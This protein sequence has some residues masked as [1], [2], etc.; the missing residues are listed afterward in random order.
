MLLIDSS[1]LLFWSVTLL[2]TLTPGLA[3][4][5]VL[6]T[7]LYEGR[8]ASALAALGIAAGNSVYL[9]VCVLGLAALL[10]RAGTLL[11]ALRL[12]G[13]AYLV[14]LGIRLL[15][16]RGETRSLSAEKAAHGSRAFGRGF[17]TQIG[18]PKAV[19]YWTALLP[20]FLDPSRS[21]AR[22]ISFFGAVAIATEI[23]VLLA[24][25]SLAAWASRRLAESPE[26]V[27]WLDRA[28]GALLIAVAAILTLPD[29]F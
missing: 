9:A 21:F 8:R 13:A 11:L 20:Q 3:V 19:L 4:Y 12:A 18:N 5:L 27:R 23:P 29:L 15:L 26:V 7:G 24:Y 2:A 10:E 14:W 6:S 16:S 17:L 22:Q 28:S 1:F 25:G